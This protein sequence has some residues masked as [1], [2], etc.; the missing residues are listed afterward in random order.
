MSSKKWIIGF[1]VLSLIAFV[2]GTLVYQKS[3]ATQAQITVAKTEAISNDQLIKFHSPALGAAN[4]KVTIVE[5][6]DPACEGCRAFYP[7]VKQIMAKYPN[8]VRLVLRFAAFHDGSDLV[9]KILLA[10]KKQGR[11]WQLLE[12]V[13]EQ[14]PAWASHSGAK[15]EM[16]WSFAENVGIDMKQVRID[17]ANTSMD[18]ILEIEKADIVALKVKQTPT[19]FVNGKPL[20]S[21]GQ[22][23]LVA[24]V[25]QSLK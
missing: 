11:F 19:F 9:V 18:S 5:F 17:V 25:E 1:A 2:V 21:F 3:Q 6:F 4:P 16:V 14:Q 10:A 12:V 15:P 13:M 20:P 22:E 24:A 7:L 23:Q 8:D